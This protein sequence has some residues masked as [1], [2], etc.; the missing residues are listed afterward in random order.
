MKKQLLF[1]GKNIYPH[2]YVE[3]QLEENTIHTLEWGGYIWRMG[4]FL[5]GYWGNQVDIKWF[6]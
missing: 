4:E 3:V 1:Q 5:S 6:I 2:K